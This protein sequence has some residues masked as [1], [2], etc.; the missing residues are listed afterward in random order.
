MQASQGIDRKEREQRIA[1][2]AYFRAERRG[3]IGGDPIADWV[4]A[5]HEIDA[6]LRKQEHGR[7]LA[8]FEARL[9]TAGKKLEALRKKASALTAEA[10]KELEQDVQ[11][12]GRLRDAFEKRLEEIRMHGAAAGHKAKEHAEALW[13]EISTLADRVAKRPRSK[14]KQ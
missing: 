6:E 8:D 13:A 5:E 14:K 9:E 1:E 10:R 7:L 3:F 11:T 12:L 2:A 4:E